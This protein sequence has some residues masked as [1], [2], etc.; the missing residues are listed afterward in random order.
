MAEAA[1]GIMESQSPAGGRGGK[2]RG[3]GKQRALNSEVAGSTNKAA[4]A[5]PPESLQAGNA[6]AP[7]SFSSNIQGLRFMQSAKENEE[8]KL[9]EKEQLRHLE[10]M[11]WVIPGFERECMAADSAQEKR[12]PELSTAAPPLLLHRRSYKGFN[13]VVELAMKDLLKKHADAVNQA[14]ELE[15]ASA[16]RGMKQRRV[17]RQ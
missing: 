4:P 6:D 16:L 8:R 5:A 3:R 2:G 11:Q 10:D 13:N 12:A 14:E 1:D 9:Q 7:H 17:A 15:Q